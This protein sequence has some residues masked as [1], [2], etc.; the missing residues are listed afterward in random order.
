MAVGRFK[1][2][3]LAKLLKKLGVKQVTSTKKKN[4]PKKLKLEAIDEA[5]KLAA[6][7]PAK[8]S[9]IGFPVGSSGDLDKASFCALGCLAAVT[10]QE[11]VLRNSILDGREYAAF[12]ES[13]MHALQRLTFDKGDALSKAVGKND[14]DED[15]SN[16]TV[17]A[18]KWLRRQVAK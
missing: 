10:A 13:P 2:I 14:R 15:K 12:A 17:K 6:L 5:L 1:R 7:R 4:W 11:A 18:L 3:N 16:T 9:F 8:N